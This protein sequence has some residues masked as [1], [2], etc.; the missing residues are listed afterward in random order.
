VHEH[1]GRSVSHDLPCQR[2]AIDGA[3]ARPYGTHKPIYRRRRARRMKKRT[4]ATANH[5]PI[6]R[7]YS[8]P[9]LSSMGESGTTTATHLGTGPYCGV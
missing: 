2:P 3:T 7:R 8:P 1:Y 4:S 6:A 9:G 5:N